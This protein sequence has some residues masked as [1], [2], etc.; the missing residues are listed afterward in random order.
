MPNEKVRYLK[1]YNLIKDKIVYVKDKDILGYDSSNARDFEFRYWK[2]KEF[3]L[4]NNFIAMDNDY[5]IGNK[6][7]KNDF[8]F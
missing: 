5:F 3:G 4:S 7:S 1:D 8:F 2:L 6:L